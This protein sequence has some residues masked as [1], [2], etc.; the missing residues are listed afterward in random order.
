ML[1]LL[2][3][4]A[5]LRL[6]LASLAFEVS[7]ISNWFGTQIKFTWGSIKVYGRFTSDSNEAQFD[8]F[9]MN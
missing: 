2:R 6:K 7:F 1:M 9:Q 5:F 8:F 4:K 3:K